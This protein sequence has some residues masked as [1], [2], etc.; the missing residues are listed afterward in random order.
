MT[1][2]QQIEA[3]STEN[4]QLRALLAQTLE[5][6]K[7]V[8]HT[9]N[10]KLLEAHSVRSKWQQRALAGV[11]TAAERV[12]SWCSRET[13]EPGYESDWA[14]RARAARDAAMS[15]GTTTVVT[16]GE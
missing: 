13:R 12:S 15:N 7:G 9:L 11:G 6:H 14:D 5:D 16:T 1:K 3:L 8:V 4:E 2:Q 10:C